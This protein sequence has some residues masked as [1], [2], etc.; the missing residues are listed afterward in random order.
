MSKKVKWNDL[1]PYDLQHLSPLERQS[2][3]ERLMRILPKNSP[4]RKALKIF[5]NS[6]YDTLGA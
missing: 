5:I 4:Q 6:Q 3:F 2:E 1:L